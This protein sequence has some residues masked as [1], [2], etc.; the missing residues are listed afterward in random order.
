MNK[1][2]FIKQDGTIP[3]FRIIQELER[4]GCENNSTGRKWNGDGLHCCYY[5]ENNQISVWSPA[6]DDPIPQLAYYTELLYNKDTDSFYETVDEHWTE[7]AQSPNGTRWQIPVS[8]IEEV[9]ERGFDAQIPIP[10]EYEAKI[11]DNKV[12]FR[13]KRWQ[14]KEEETFYYASQTECLYFEVRSAIN[15]DYSNLWRY[16]MSKG[17]CFQKEEE[18]QVFCDKINAAIKPITDERLKEIG[19]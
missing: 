4:R 15:Y 14:P 10:K 18:A 2:V 17:N 3:K 6:F 13:K 7:E 19:Q 1:K 8:E 9:V 11:E 12:I 16:L 5:I